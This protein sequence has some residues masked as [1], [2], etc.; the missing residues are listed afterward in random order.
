VKTD[1]DS[2]SRFWVN[3]QSVGLDPRDRGLAYGDGLFETMAC[4]DGSIRRIDYHFE[5]LAHGCGRL[6]IPVPDRGALRSEI[7]NRCRGS[8]SAVV[9]LIVTRGI[10]ERGYKPPEPAVPNTILSITPWSGYPRRQYTHGVDIRVCALR[11]AEN[12]QLAGLKHLCRLEQVLAQMELVGD[13]AEEG[14]VRDRSGFIVG[15]ISTNVFAVRGAVLSTPRLTRCGVHGVMRRAVLDNAGRVGLETNQ[16]DLM[17]SDLLESDELF[18]TN[19]VAGIRPVRSLDGGRFEIGPHT[20][21][22]MRLLGDAAEQPGGTD[23][24]GGTDA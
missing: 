8:A 12:P 22:L 24:R 7:E 9:K 21:A 2:A 10:G 1:P 11:L 18:I 14:L 15:G 13:P 16:Q 5:R 3:G 23:A 20:H 6:A 19:A 4:R 17:L